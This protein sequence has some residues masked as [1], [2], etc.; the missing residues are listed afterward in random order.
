MADHVD[1]ARWECLALDVAELQ[2]LARQLQEV[3]ASI[4]RFEQALPRSCPSE[5]DSAA[6]STEDTSLPQ[7]RAC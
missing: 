3:F 1:A 7:E 6:C 4:R 2:T 5:A